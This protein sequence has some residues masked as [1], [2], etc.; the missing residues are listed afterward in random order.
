MDGW[1]AC[2][3]AQQAAEKAL[4][5]VLIAAGSQPPLVHELRALRTLMPSE[6]DLGTTD[7]EL[8]E[9]T[10]YATG[11][12]HVFDAAMGAEDPTW[13]EAARAVVTA[14]RIERAVRLYLGLD[15]A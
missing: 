6:L 10:M 5:A 8:S 11:S 9:L 3:H 7:S 4:K 2:F 12:R 14:A 1:A 15:R 13:N